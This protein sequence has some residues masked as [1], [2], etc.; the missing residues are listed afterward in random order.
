MKNYVKAVVLA[1][2]SPE[3]SYAAG[4]PAKDAGFGR[5]TECHSCERTV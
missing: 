4:C 5:K 1:K 3:G 2:N